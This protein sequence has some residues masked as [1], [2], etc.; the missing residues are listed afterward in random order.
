M[1]NAIYSELDGIAKSIMLEKLQENY[2][3]GRLMWE[4]PIKFNYITGG[5]VYGLEVPLKALKAL[6]STFGDSDLY[7]LYQDMVKPEFFDVSKLSGVWDSG[8]YP[9]EIS[10]LWTIENLII[11]DESQQWF[12]QFNAYLSIGIVVF[13]KSVSP[14]LLEI[15]M[16]NYNK[17]DMLIDIS[18]ALV[19]VR[20]DL[21]DYGDFVENENKLKKCYSKAVGYV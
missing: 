14:E 5:V 11:F 1:N 2:K 15:A 10:Y 18:Q 3:L 21:S 4:D 13:R 19:N 7:F 8:R 6:S 17:Y 16:S 20:D 9:A 12:I